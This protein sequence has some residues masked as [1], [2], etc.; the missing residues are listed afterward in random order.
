MSHSPRA[1]GTAGVNAGVNA[2]LASFLFVAVIP[3][4][5]NTLLKI[6]LRL[7]TTEFALAVAAKSLDVNPVAAS[8]GW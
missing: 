6:S 2:P 1:A 3:K 5:Y 8:H 7:A 4:K